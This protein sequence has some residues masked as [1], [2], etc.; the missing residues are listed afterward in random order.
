MRH[1][2]AQ[3]RAALMNMTEDDTPFK[4]STTQ[5]IFKN[6]PNVSLRGATYD[7]KHL[8]SFLGS[9]FGEKSLQV[10]SGNVSS[11][12]GPGG[13]GGSNMVNFMMSGSSNQIKPSVSFLSMGRKDY[14]QIKYTDEYDG[15]SPMQTLGNE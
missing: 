12:P 13:G 11:R 7:A 14:K 15:P 1:Q 10:N 6:A 4:P 8:D 2:E 3:K 9:G 5:K